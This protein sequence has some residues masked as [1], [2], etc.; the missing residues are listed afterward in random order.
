[1]SEQTT[2]GSYCIELLGSN[3]WMPWKCQMQAILRDLGIEEFIEEESTPPVAK[4]PL[5]GA[6]IRSGKQVMQRPGPGSN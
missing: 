3:N 4:T 5:T 1:M 2:G 6:D